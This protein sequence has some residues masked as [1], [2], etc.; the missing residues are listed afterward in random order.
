LFFFP[1][2]LIMA[3]VEFDT[4]R[5]RARLMRETGSE[6]EVGFLVGVALERVRGARI[7]EFV[8]LPA[9]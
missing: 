8:T 3:D 9:S 7:R 4:T 6:A 2:S 1:L 5:L